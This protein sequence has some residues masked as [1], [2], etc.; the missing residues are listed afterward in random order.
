MAVDDHDFEKFKTAFNAELANMYK[1]NRDSRKYM[2][3]ER[4]E[5]IINDLT[6]SNDTKRNKNDYRIKLT[7]REVQG[8]RIL[9]FKDDFNS[10]LKSFQIVASEDYFDVLW[11]LHAVTGHGNSD[12]LSKLVTKKKYFIPNH[13]IAL[14]I[15]LC[16]WCR[17]REPEN[18]STSARL[19][20]A[21]TTEE[22]DSKRGFFEIIN[23]TATPDGKYN[24]I[25]T[26]QDMK[27]K[28]SI[29]RPVTNIF[30]IDV[31]S[32]LLQIFYDIGF[33]R[34]LY[35]LT[36]NFTSDIFKALNKQNEC[37]SLLYGKP[38]DHEEGRVELLIRDWMKKNNSTKW[39][40][41]INFVQ[42]IL[43]SK[44]NDELGMTPF[45]A[46]FGFGRDAAA[47]CV[48]MSAEDASSLRNEEN[49]LVA[50][51]S[52]IATC[53]RNDDSPKPRGDLTPESP[54]GP[55]SSAV[56]SDKSPESESLNI[57][58]CWVCTEE[59]D[60]SSTCSKCD[61]N[62]HKECGRTI[63]NS[64]VCIVCDEDQAPTEDVYV[65]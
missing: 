20:N 23:M 22:T 50:S 58:W 34:I 18:P 41:G 8:E 13:V 12:N 32:E 4:I 47:T 24:C 16:P 54:K 25:V 52:L 26:Y 37:L 61:G 56:A 51:D 40:M 45:K 5:K 9:V 29:L 7:V 35:T 48:N 44:F 27:S 39:T 14:W 63:K 55:T 3:R 42:F 1:T 21:C 49:V 59:G 43:N 36:R 46:M 60:L 57:D 11:P 17:C 65:E 30:E 62:I 31:T 6:S 53:E 19:E 64:V 15:K 2:T 38:N 28:F 10:P 33:P